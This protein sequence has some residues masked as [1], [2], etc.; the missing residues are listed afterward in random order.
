MTAPSKKQTLFDLSGG[1]PAL[2]LVNSLDNRFRADGPNENLVHYSDLLRFLGESGLLDPQRIRLLDKAASEQAAEQVLRA[3][4]EL[5]EAAAAVFYAGMEGRTPAH[6]HVLT[7]E[8]HFVEASRHRELHWKA[9]GSSPRPPEL[10]LPPPMP[11]MSITIFRHAN[12]HM[13]WR[14]RRSSRRDGS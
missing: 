11:P 12:C 9:A 10:P 14:A 7:L 2:D 13:A 8:R 6:S 3:V 1:H 5:R 4:K